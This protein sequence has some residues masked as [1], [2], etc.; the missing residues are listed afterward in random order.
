MADLVNSCSKDGMNIL[1][2]EE[3]DSPAMKRSSLV[4]ASMVADGQRAVIGVIG[5][6][7]MNYEKVIDAIDRVL[8]GLDP[9]SEREDS[10][11]E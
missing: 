4:A 10:A 7:R 2:G 8:Q 6:E 9:E 5:P 1:I 3:N 11:N